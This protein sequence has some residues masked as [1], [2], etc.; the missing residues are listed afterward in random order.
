[1][2]IMSDKAGKL[3]IRIDDRLIHGQIVYGWIPNWPAEEV[4]LLNDRAADD[5]DE[6]KLYLNLL[7]GVSRGGITTVEDGIKRFERGFSANNNILLIVASCGDALSLVRGNVKATEIHIGN[8]ASDELE[9]VLK[10]N[11]FIGEDDIVMLKEIEE[12]GYQVL[13]R[14]LPSSEPILASSIFGEKV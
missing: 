7:N 2:A 3:I 5:E 8:L 1:V 13:L 12:R 11:L 4:W 9:G 10:D 6:K 14:K